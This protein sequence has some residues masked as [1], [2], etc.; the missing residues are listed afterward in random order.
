MGSLQRF[1]SIL[2][3]KLL[4]HQYRRVSSSGEGGGGEGRG[5]I[6]MKTATVHILVVTPA[7]AGLTGEE[8]RLDSDFMTAC[9]I[10]HPVASSI[11]VLR[12]PP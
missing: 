6:C 3:I 4:I 7:H 10:Y 12:P 5:Y 2:C 1:C 11:N 8:A 9:Y